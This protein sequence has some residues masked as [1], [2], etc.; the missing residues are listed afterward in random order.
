MKFI[1]TTIAFLSTWCL[2]QT[3]LADEY[4]FVTADRPTTASYVPAANLSYNSAGLT[5]R[6]YRLSRGRFH[7]KMPAAGTPHHGGNVQVSAYGGTH[8]CRASSWGKSANV[9]VNV[10]VRC[11]NILGNLTDGKFTVLYHD[12]APYGEDVAFAWIDRSVPT[13]PYGRNPN[14]YYSHNSGAV[15]PTGSNL[16]YVRVREGVYWVYMAEFTEPERNWLVTA[17]GGNAVH[18]NLAREDQESAYV[19]GEDWIDRMFAE[20]RCYDTHGY[21]ADSRFTIAMAQGR[22]FGSPYAASANVHMDQPTASSSRAARETSWNSEST[23]DSSI[24]R[25]GVGEYKVYLWSMAGKYTQATA[26]VTAESAYANACS[27]QG[28]QDVWVFTEV[29]VK[30]N[31]AWGAPRDTEFHLT[32]L[33]GE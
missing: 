28:W 2:A 9:D 30:C 26:L 33:A 8:R 27:V 4:S 10:Y 11:F 20:V 5:N 12:A 14:G 29:T 21:P 3:T 16:W 24:S 25:T 22:G 15:D 23:T 32:F 17:Y 19:P 6:V 7:V 31:S 18:C 13:E 1:A